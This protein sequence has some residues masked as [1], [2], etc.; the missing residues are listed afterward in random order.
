MEALGFIAPRVLHPA[1]TPAPGAMFL[2][3]ILLSFVLAPNGRQALSPSEQGT[4]AQSIDP[5]QGRLAW[6]QGT[7][8]ECLAEAVKSRRIVFLDFWMDW[9]PYSKKLATITF[10]SDSVVTEMKDILCYS[11][12]A[13]GKEGKA[14][15]RQFQARGVPTLVFL[16]PDGT[17]RDQLTGYFP[18]EPFLVEVRRIK[19]NEGTLSELRG[20][21]Q[22]APGDLEARW[23]LA[24]KLKAIGDLPGY[25]EQVAAI[26]ERDPEGKTVAS[27]RLRFEELRARAEKSLDLEPLYAFV[28]G[29]QDRGLLFE[30]WR[31]IW[32]LEGQS[33]RM[34]RDPEKVKAHERRWVAA[35]RKLWPLVPAE[36]HGPLGNKI[37]WG[38]YEHRS[39]LAP[40]DLRFAL[41]VAEKAVEAAPDTPWIVDTLACCLF[42]VGRR[43]EAIATVQR[44]IELD[45]KN[46]QWRERLAEFQSARE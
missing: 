6:F 22:T 36:E 16:D 35:A 13:R 18:P 11:V 7:W 41:S 15:A 38:F 34:A 31:D 17:L 26:R 21:I 5:K 37:A 33:A 1:L 43:A 3:S 40:E 28:E 42:A 8:Q 12:D 32:V 23:K 27:R 24:Q 2:T 20:R 30:G 29:E 39:N 19:R 9:C 4:A 46:P 14:L 10:A 45:P 25:E 44:C